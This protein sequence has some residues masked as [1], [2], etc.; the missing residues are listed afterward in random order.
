MATREEQKRQTRQRLIA[1]ALELFAQRG[2]GA[3]RTMDVARAAGVAHGTVFA[4]FPT[5]DDLVTAVIEAFAGTLIGRLNE[6][7]DRG[8][9]VRE[10]L[11]AH[12]EGLIEHE[13]LYARLVMEGPML[14]RGSRT[15]MLAIQSVV[16]FHLYGAAEK[17]WERNEL[18]PMPQH[19]LF[20]TWL[21]LVHH[22]LCNQDLFAP[23]ESALARHG[24]ELLDHYMGLLAP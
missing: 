22:Y 21:G 1:V 24:Q 4:H 10:V 7:A 14:P 3:T 9:G 19:L 15:T 6:L 17:G 13:A 11:A 16:S 5:R 8:A 18:R 12:M 2:I 20:N 23:N